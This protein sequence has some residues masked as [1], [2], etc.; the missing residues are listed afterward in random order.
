MALALRTKAKAESNSA[1][2]LNVTVPG[3][4]SDGDLLVAWLAYEDISAT[5]TADT[6]TWI[7]FAAPGV[8]GTT[9][10]TRAFYRVASN[11]PDTWVFSQDGVADDFGVQVAAF[12]NDVGVGAWTL[13]D[14]QYSQVDGV[15]SITTT[16]ITGAANS[17]YVLGCLQD[18]NE[19]VE[20]DP[21]GPTKI[22]EVGNALAP[23]GQVGSISLACW[24]ELVGAGGITDTIAWS[25][26][27]EEIIAHAAVFTNNASAGAVTIDTIGD[28]PFSD[29]KSV[30][31]I[32]VG[33]E[34]AKGTG[35]VIICPT[36]DVTD[37][38]AETQTDTAWSTGD[39]IT[40]TLVRGGLAL[41]TDVYVF[42][43]NDSGASNADGKVIQLSPHYTLDFAEGIGV[44]F[45]MSF[46]LIPARTPVASDWDTR[47]RLGG[48]WFRI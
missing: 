29:G 14:Q 35:S 42:V 2:S 20:T 43:T 28:T 11:E 48:G 9:M 3:G 37:V 19:N 44:I 4:V 31:L 27:L 25:G 39:E 30:I 41:D 10:T 1:T 23:D 5:I 36:D 12:Y 15:A 22:Y 33:F 34:L 47:H 38:N 8:A 32:G 17:L 7:E 21:T 26:G 46:S 16:E 6:G 24:Y 18:D 13:E 45:N 40:F